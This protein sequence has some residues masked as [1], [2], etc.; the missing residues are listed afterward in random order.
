MSISINNNNPS[1][2]TYI[3][4]VSNENV[5]SDVA[6]PV[7]ENERSFDQVSIQGDSRAQAEERI[8]TGMQSKLIDKVLSS[9]DDSSKIE[10]LKSRIQQG[11]YQID[12]NRIAGRILYM[13]G[14]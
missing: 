11:L 2:M 14:E 9:K 3:N 7:K 4:R 13:K 1:T 10:D 12:A 5:K 6:T 8:A